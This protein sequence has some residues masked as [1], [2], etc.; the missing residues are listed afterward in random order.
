MNHEHIAVWKIL[1]ALNPYAKKNNTNTFH[2]RSQ[3][4]SHSHSRQSFH[5]HSK[6]Y[7]SLVHGLI[8]L[9]SDNEQIPRGMS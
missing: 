3:G 6:R 4:S 8:V 2:N 1:I 7:G 5:N 9:C